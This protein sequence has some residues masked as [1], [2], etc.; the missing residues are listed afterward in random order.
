MK[1]WNENICQCIFIENLFL[2]VL[3]VI[4]SDNRFIVYCLIDNDSCSLVCASIWFYFILKN[5]KGWH[6]IRNIIW[7][8]LRYINQCKIWISHHYLVYLCLSLVY[9][10]YVWYI[11]DHCEV[12][13][14]TSI[15]QSPL[16]L[17]DALC[18]LSAFFIIHCCFVVSLGFC[19]IPKKLILF[20]D[21]SS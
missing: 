9:L 11:C 19:L 15:F 7:S 10:W 4:H 2:A 3:A 21:R 16:M 14:I 6:L 13:M 20:R 1:G 18:F 12:V 5:A 17:L 8:Y